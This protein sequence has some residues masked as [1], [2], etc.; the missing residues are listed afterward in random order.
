MCVCVYVFLF[1]QSVTDVHSKQEEEEKKKN[2]LLWDRGLDQAVTQFQT[3]HDDS[4]EPFHFPHVFSKRLT[5]KVIIK[6]KVKGRKSTVLDLLKKVLNQVSD[7]S[8]L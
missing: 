6:K 1:S 4:L 2:A 5:R 3:L 8:H 7:E